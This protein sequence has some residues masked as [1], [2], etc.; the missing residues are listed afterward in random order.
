[1]RIEIVS[2]VGMLERRRYEFVCHLDSRGLHIKLTSMT[3]E[4]KPA[5]GARVPF[6]VSGR[7]DMYEAKMLEMAPSKRITHE[8]KVPLDV[9]RAM[10][11][12]LEAAIS[13]D[14][15]VCMPATAEPMRA[16]QH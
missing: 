5:T 6:E 2:L 13:Y 7:W 8:P 12:N 4:T 3:V 11:R 14:F 1:M 16:T 15:Q 9:Q 10:R